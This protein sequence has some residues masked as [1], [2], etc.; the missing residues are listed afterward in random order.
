MKLM[1][2]YIDRNFLHATIT[3]G[4]FSL[5]I[6]QTA[7]L[8]LSASTEILIFALN[9]R[10]ILSIRELY[11]QALHGQYVDTG[12]G[13]QSGTATHIGTRLHFANVGLGSTTIGADDEVPMGSLEKGK[14]KHADRV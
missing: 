8:V 7:G 6:S 2:I 3:Q 14:K 4:L 5:A 10:F 13:M 12:F 1:D 11:A 9:P